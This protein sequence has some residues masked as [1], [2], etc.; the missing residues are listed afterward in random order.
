[1]EVEWRAI[2]SATGFHHRQNDGSVLT[3]GLLF[4]SEA[5][6]SKDDGLPQSLFSRVIFRRDSGMMNK[7]EQTETLVAQSTTGV[8]RPGLIT[9]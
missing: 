3:A 5:Q 4:G 1:M 6:L 8:R 2:D 9:Q 7:H